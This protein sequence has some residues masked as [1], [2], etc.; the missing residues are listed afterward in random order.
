MKK[1]QNG[2]KLSMAARK[3]I[4]KQAQ[5]EARA[6]TAAMINKLLEQDHHYWLVRNEPPLYNMNWN[7]RGRENY[8]KKGTSGFPAA[9]FFYYTLEE[10]RIKDKHMKELVSKKILAHKVREMIAGTINHINANDVMDPDKFRRRLESYK[11]M[12]ED[13]VRSMR[14]AVDFIWAPV[15]DLEDQLLGETY[16]LREEQINFYLA[17]LRDIAHKRMLPQRIDM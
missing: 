9:Q 3:Q 11:V 16:G 2:Q 4:V 13:K 7:Y 10:W 14:Q 15:R 12:L 8:V 5:L 6:M 1:A 17:P